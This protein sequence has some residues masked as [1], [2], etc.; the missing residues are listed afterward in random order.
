MPGAGGQKHT[1]DGRVILRIDPATVK[2]VFDSFKTFI[3]ENPID[4]EKFTNVKE[5]IDWLQ[6]SCQQRWIPHLL[7]SPAYAQCRLFSTYNN[8]A[9]SVSLIQS[10]QSSLLVCC[11][12]YL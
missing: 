6:D 12:G 10:K 4:T 8:I 11:Y 3:G 2:S 7:T 1:R 5:F 9:Y